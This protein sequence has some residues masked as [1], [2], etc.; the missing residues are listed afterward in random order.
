MNPEVF[1][2][3]IPITAIIMIGLVKIARLWSPGQQ[4]QGDPE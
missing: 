4:C 2:L 3:L 1:V